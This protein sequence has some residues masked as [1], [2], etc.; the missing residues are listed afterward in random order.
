MGETRARLPAVILLAPICFWPCAVWAQDATWDF[1]PQN[2]NFNVKNNWSTNSV[3]SGTAT[4][5]PSNTT[6]IRLP[7]SVSIGGMTFTPDAPAYTFNSVNSNTLTFTGAGIVNNSPFAPTF[8]NNANNDVMSFLG[9]ATAGNAIINNTNSSSTL[10]FGD[11]SSAGN[12]TITNTGTITFGASATAANSTIITDSGGLVTFTG[13]ADGGPAQLITNAGGTVNISGLNASMQV[14]SIAGAGNYVLGGSSLTVGTNDLSS[15][16]SGVISGVGGQLTKVGTGTLTLAGVNT[17]T[18]GTAVNGGTLN[19]TGSLASGVTVNNTGTLAGTG[20]INGNTTIHSGGIISPGGLV[21]I[22]VGGTFTQNAGSSYA[23][24][25]AATGQ[26][27]SIKVTGAAVLNGGMVNLIAQPGEYAHATTYT[28]LTATGG[29]TGIYAGISNTFDF[30]TESLSY[31]GNNVILTLNFNGFESGAKTQDE[32]NV[33]AVLD[34]FTSKPGSPLAGIIGYLE[35]LQGPAGPAALDAIGG[36][37]Y[38]NLGT[39]DVYVAGVFMNAI[40]AQTSITHGGAGGGAR[41]ALAEACN[42]DCDTSQ[43]GKFSAWLSGIGGIGSVPGDGNANTLAYSFGGT[44]FGVDYRINPQFLIG[45]SGAFASGSQSVNGFM[46]QALTSAWSGSV[47]GSFTRG[48]FY[49]DGSAGYS[50][51]TQW[52]QRP[53]SIPGLSLLIAQGQV[54]ADQFLGQFETGYKLDLPMKAPLAIT[55]FVRAQGSTTNQ[56]RWSRQAPMS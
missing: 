42:L 18:G 4:F 49:L 37:P 30:F 54:S 25:I 14:G 27:D 26:S 36:Q 32:H 29:V 2:G 7:T 1:N 16:V 38:A 21:P 44:A 47:Y 45:L 3:P 33:A 46:G 56:G 17:Y 10:S 39:M 22:N 28:I 40:L 51:Y 43:L 41:V 53:I 5:G 52:M 35:V 9:G 20:T 19:L 48:P 50:H 11:S 6:T 8:N 55:P 23:P 24:N 12:A 13:N 34:Q 31:N 15:T